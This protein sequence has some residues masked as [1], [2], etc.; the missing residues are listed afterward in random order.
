MEAKLL[1]LY[2]KAALYELKVC[3]G[4]LLLRWMPAETAQA[5]L[6]CCR[7]CCLAENLGTTLIDRLVQKYMK[8]I[9]SAVQVKVRSSW[10]H[11]AGSW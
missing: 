11:D 9:V 6:T 5:L 7:C 8:C 3:I 4:R 2:M 10:E 1:A